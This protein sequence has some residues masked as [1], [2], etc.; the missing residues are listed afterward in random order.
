MQAQPK[1]ILETN[2]TMG[3]D[4]WRRLRKLHLHP[5]EVAPTQSKQKT[6][7]SIIIQIIGRTT[8]LPCIVSWKWVFKEYFIVHN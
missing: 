7:K 3:A 2:P 1:Q 6:Q 4:P 8:K 5:M